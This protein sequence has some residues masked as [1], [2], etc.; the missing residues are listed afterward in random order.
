MFFSQNVLPLA[1]GVM[2]STHLQVNAKDHAANA[3]HCEALKEGV[4]ADNAISPLPQYSHQPPRRAVERKK[5]YF[6]TQEWADDFAKA[7]VKL[8]E[9]E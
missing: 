4:D 1:R 6:T 3:I 8:Q 7:L 5:V 2:Q 9:D